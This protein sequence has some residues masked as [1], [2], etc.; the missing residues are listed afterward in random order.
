MTNRY[1]VYPVRLISIK[2][3]RKYLIDIIKYIIYCEGPFF[4]S[5]YGEVDC[6]WPY[7]KNA[8][9]KNCKIENTGGKKNYVCKDY[10]NW[11]KCKSGLAKRTIQYP[12]PPK[13][14][15][16]LGHCIHINI[17]VYECS[18]DGKIIQ[19]YQNET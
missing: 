9:W 2:Q 7:T 14:S 4:V 18:T 5:Y 13:D 19:P 11:N 8:N 10:V 17:A 12:V 3:I 1:L 15:L 6:K 16:K